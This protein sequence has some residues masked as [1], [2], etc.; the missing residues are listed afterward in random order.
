M[1]K[2]NKLKIIISS[3]FLL[4]IVASAA[5]AYFGS[6]NINVNNNVAVNIITED[7]GEATFVSNAT[8]L[9]LQVKK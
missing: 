1:E 9:N 3:I 8:F 2:N 5:F 4:V 7:P 6:F